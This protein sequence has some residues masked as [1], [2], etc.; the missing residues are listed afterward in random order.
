MKQKQYTP[1]SVAEMGLSLFAA[2]EGFLKGV[3][4]DKI[5]A[6]EA[7]LVAYFNSEHADL[8]AKVNEKGG[9]DDEIAAQFKAGIE[10]FKSTQTW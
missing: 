8:M 7:A 3:E 5:G 1:M 9:Y 10:K 4:L 6:F 2:N